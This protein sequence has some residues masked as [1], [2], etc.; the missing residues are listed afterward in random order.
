MVGADGLLAR[1]GA[2]RR[3]C[4]DR[5]GPRAGTPPSP[6]AERLV[7]RHS[8]STRSASASASASAGPPSQKTRVSPRV[9]EEPQGVAAR[10]TG[11]RDRLR[12]AAPRRRARRVP[13]R[14]R[15]APTP[16]RRSRSGLA[17]GRQRA[18]RSAACAGGCRGR[19]GR[20]SGVR[21]PARRTVR[22]GSSASTVPTPTRIASA[23][24]RIRCIRAFAPS[25]VIMSRGPG[26]ARGKAVRGA[27]ELQGRWRV[28]PPSRAVMWPR[29]ARRASSAR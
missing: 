7:T 22:S 5:S 17:C 20:A 13:A 25:P 11:R 1:R 28:G 16:S 4:A 9:P 3:A 14:L 15:P 26:A 19:R 21:G 10:S 27:G 8:S 2:V 24:A 23:W 29:W 18:A 6:S 12:R